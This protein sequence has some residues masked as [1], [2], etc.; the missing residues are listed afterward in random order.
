MSMDLRLKTPKRVPG[1][2]CWS[3]WWDSIQTCLTIHNS[4]ESISPKL[5][6]KRLMDNWGLKGG[7]F[8]PKLQTNPHYEKKSNKST[9]KV[10]NLTTDLCPA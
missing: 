1:Q 4:M 7:S 5:F 6:R 2:E 8:C 3:I 9:Q 10:K